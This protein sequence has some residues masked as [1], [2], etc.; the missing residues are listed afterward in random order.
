[1]EQIQAVRWSD[2]RDGVRIL[3]QRLL[4]GGEVYRDLRSVDEGRG[5]FKPLAVPGAPAIGIAAAMGLTLTLRDSRGVLGPRLT[6]TDGQLRGTRPTAVNFTRALDRMMSVVHR[7][8]AD[9]DGLEAALR[10]EAT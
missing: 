8:R 7:H 3:D 4:P 2:D 10:E 1:M 9:S 6:A 5:A